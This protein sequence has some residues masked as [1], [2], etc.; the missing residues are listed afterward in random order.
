MDIRGVR[1]AFRRAGGGR[2]RR[3]GPDLE[4]PL[5]FVIRPRAFDGPTTAR[6]TRRSPAARGVEVIAKPTVVALWQTVLGRPAVTDDQ[7][8]PCGTSRGAPRQPPQR[9]ATR[10]PSRTVAFSDGSAASTALSTAVWR[11]CRHR[12]WI[13][14]FVVCLISPTSPSRGS[15]SRQRSL[16]SADPR[17]AAPQ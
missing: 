8:D 9:Q 10:R 12:C 15:S 13:V 17:A 16:F 5:R 6:R 2:G 1:G 4:P 3:G 11:K 7:P 14:H